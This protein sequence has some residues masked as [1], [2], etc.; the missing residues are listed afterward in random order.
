M[1]LF[2][3]V[4]FHVVFNNAR[5]LST[6]SRHARSIGN[7]DQ[8]ESI[9]SA[10]QVNVVG[11]LSSIG[12][13]DQ[14]ESIA[15]LARVKVVGSLS[16]HRTWRRW[17]E[18]AIDLIRQ[19]LILTLPTPVDQAALS[20]LS[21]SLGTAADL[22]IMPSF[23]NKGALAGYATEYFCR[24]QL[25]ADLLLEQNEPKFLVQALDDLLSES[26]NTD[27][28][29]CRLVSLGGGPGFDFCALALMT[30][31][32]QQSSS[33][34]ST[35]QSLATSPIHPVSA[36]V[37]DYEHGWGSLVYAMASSVDAV[38]GGS[39]SC[40]FG[41]CDIT[42]PLSDPVNEACA[43]LVLTTDLWA[44]SYVIAENAVKLREGKYDFFRDVFCQAKQGA[45]FVF[46]ETTHRI[47]PELV[48]VA[49]ETADFDV[50]FPRRNG[51]GKS[52]RQFILRKR[53]GARIGEEERKHLTYFERD[54]AAHQ[55]K[56]RDG[57]YRR[58]ERK[59]R[60]AK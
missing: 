30:T 40:E 53:E 20:D 38:L 46:T 6:V 39:H 12:N 32:H 11:S 1:R 13:K 43:S 37:L 18:C 26:T 27:A 29:P 14:L 4:S 49:M 56:V 25:L 8:L 9:A 7:K 21:R 55:L 51:R 57:Y 3:V 44:C 33:R 17:S 31:F 54:N 22:G 23:Q 45:L 48:S 52:G 34:T 10:A 47:W 2:R 5:A 60:G 15:S 28:T 35:S 24:A 19:N 36:T 59:I 50:V 41:G 16:Y 58:K 42:L